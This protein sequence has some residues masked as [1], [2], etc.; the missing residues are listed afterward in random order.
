VEVW[1]LLGL[2][3]GAAYVLRRA[4]LHRFVDRETAKNLRF[5]ERTLRWLVLAMI[6]AVALI[7]LLLNPK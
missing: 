7:L 2:G 4:I 3:I 1:I 6:I 5:L